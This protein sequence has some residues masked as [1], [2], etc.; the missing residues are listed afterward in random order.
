MM[1]HEVAL[2]ET[3]ALQP[4]RQ[5]MAGL[6]ALL[7]DGEFSN[8]KLADMFDTDPPWP[9]IE[10]RREALRRFSAQ[11]GE[12]E[13]R[14]F[15]AP[16]SDVLVGRVRAESGE[17]RRMIVSVAPVEPHRIRAVFVVSDPPDVSIR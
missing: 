1:G 13:V 8:Q 6:I 9:P 12:F 4:V 14:S 11:L 16:Q 3:P 5:A 10:G 17:P 2:D 7:R 15:E